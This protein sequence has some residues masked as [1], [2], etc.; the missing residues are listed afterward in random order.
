MRGSPNVC[1]CQTNM[2]WSTPATLGTCSSPRYRGKQKKPRIYCIHMAKSSSSVNQNCGIPITDCWKP[3]LNRT[4][5]ATPTFSWC[6]TFYLC[7]HF[8]A[9]CQLYPDEGSRIAAEMLVSLHEIFTKT[10]AGIKD[11]IATM[12]DSYSSSSTSSFSFQF[13]FFFFSFKRSTSKV[14]EATTTIFTPIIFI[15]A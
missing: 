7:I 11:I 1:S 5:H 13:F 12:S 10:Q 8:S 14:A 3:I 15:R 9:F 6:H 4:C 2:D